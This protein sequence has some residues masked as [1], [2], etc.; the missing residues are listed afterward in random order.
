VIVREVRGYVRDEHIGEFRRRIARTLEGLRRQDGLIKVEVGRQIERGGERFL[1]VSF[2]RD[3]DSIYRW[4]GG[5]DLLFVPASGGGFAE[6]WDQH[7]VQHWEVME[8]EE[9]SEQAVDESLASFA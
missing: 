6:V 5:T 8:F 9:A 1:F 4:V 3:L 7:E 2:W